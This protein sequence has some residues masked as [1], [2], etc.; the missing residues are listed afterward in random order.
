MKNE[1][2]NDKII[3]GAILMIL[4]YSV[5]VALRHPM[6]WELA[7]TAILPLSY[8]GSTKISNLRT[9]LMATKILSIIYGIIS[10]YA[11][12]ACILSGFM[13]NAGVWI[14]LKNLI[15]NSPV[16]FGFLALSICVCRKCGCESLPC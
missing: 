2:T 15:A 16:V 9:K 7:A 12:A 10:L 4:T 5:V 6:T 1:K 8:I 14:S 13:D 3:H 11:F